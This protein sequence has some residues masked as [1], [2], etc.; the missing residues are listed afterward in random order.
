MPSFQLLDLI[1]VHPQGLWVHLTGALWLDSY[2]TSTPRYSQ[3]CVVYKRVSCVS[4]EVVNVAV[5]VTRVC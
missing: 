5:R 2:N 4:V 3:G 1:R